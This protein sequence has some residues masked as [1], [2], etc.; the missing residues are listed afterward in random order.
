MTAAVEERP[1]PL[2]EAAQ[3]GSPFFNDINLL[4]TVEQPETITQRRLQVFAGETIRELKIQLRKKEYF[5]NKHCLIFGNRELLEDETIGQVSE[6]CAEHG[7]LHVVAK[8]SGIEQLEVT[9]DDQKRIVKNENNSMP[10]SALT[11]AV[12]SSNKVG[13]EVVPRHLQSDAGDP[14][15]HLIIKKSSKVHWHHKKGDK[16]EMRITADRPVVE[17]VPKLEAAA[18]TRST[19]NLDRRLEPALSLS[20]LDIQEGWLLEVEETPLCLEELQPT[21]GPKIEMPAEWAK[22]KEALARGVKPKLVQVG[23]GGSYYI[24][25]PE[26]AKLAIFKPED[27]EPRAPNNPKGHR[28]SPTGDGL[29]KGVRPGEGATREVIASV[30]DHDRFSGVPTTAMACLRDCG[31]SSGYRKVGSFQQFVHHVSDCE[32]MGPSSFPV[33]EVHKICVL[34][35]R[36]ANTDRNGSNILADRGEGGWVLTPIDHGY[37]LPDSFE[38]INF[39]WLYWPQAK[40]PFSERT[41]DYIRSLDADRD[42]ELI[43]KVGLALRPECKRVFR[44]CNMLLKKALT[45]GL[46]PYQIGRIM[47]RESTMSPLEKLHKEAI[48]LTLG[49]MY[50]HSTPSIEGLE[51]D[52]D[53][54]LETMS[55]NIDQYLEEIDVFE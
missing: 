3:A 49:K 11:M 40:T 5:T 27:E 31:E 44:V 10:L 12:N 43:A 22:A 39:E 8:L 55:N 33:E 2:Q 37:C 26:G 45:W 14:V 16:F 34:D 1:L 23:T 19:P 51:L 42:L 36:L 25:T 35:I 6:E 52:E 15:V 38:D 32:E 47:C 30:L 53:L 20:Q 7:F 48:M 28:G 21:A 24:A 13:M 54:Y 4:L 50:R 17:A 9:T 18:G 29:R 41:K 46:T